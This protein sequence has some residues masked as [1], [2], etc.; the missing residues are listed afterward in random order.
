[1]TAKEALEKL[2]NAVA[3]KMAK[4]ANEH[5]VDVTNLYDNLSKVMA[6]LT[7]IAEIAPVVD[8]LRK[9]GVGNYFYGAFSAFETN[10]IKHNL[11]FADRISP[12]QWLGYKAGG[13]CGEK[14][15][16]VNVNTGKWSA[17]DRNFDNGMGLEEFVH[18]ASDSCFVKNSANGFEEEIDK[19]V[20]SV[21]EAVEKYAKS[22]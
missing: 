11:G 15:L 21:M 14:S 8:K 13:Y 5:Q 18:Y 20:A 7:T 17:K 1:M 4:V 10:G 19:Y 2:D 3:S 9:L 6:K 22:A 12:H 16:F